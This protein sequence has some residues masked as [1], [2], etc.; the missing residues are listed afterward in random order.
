MVHKVVVEIRDMNGARNG[1][2]NTATAT[3]T[4]VDI[5]DN[6]P[7]FRE[8]TVGPS[9]RPERQML[10]VAHP[11]SPGVIQRDKGRYSDAHIPSRTK[12]TFST[13]GLSFGLFNPCSSP[14]RCEAT[15]S[16]RSPS[17]LIPVFQASSYEPGAEL[18]GLE[19]STTFV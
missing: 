7:T 11:V 8:A 12:T 4:L 3:V 18:N 16:T 6:P 13:F 17:L 15:G 14:L 1:L 2:S 10:M 5:N 19:G 9:C